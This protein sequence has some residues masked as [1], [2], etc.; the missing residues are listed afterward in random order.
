VAWNSLSKFLGNKSLG[1]KEISFRKYGIY[2]FLLILVIIASLASPT[3]LK[4]QNIIDILYQVAALGIVSIGQTFVILTGR[5]G[6]DLSVASV[7][8]TVAVLMANLTGGE[9]GLFLP[10]A[11]LCLVFGIT[12]G[13]CNGLL[14]TKRRVPPFMATLGMMIILQGL[15]FIYTR[16]APKGNFPPV[17][18]FLGTGNIGPVP[19]SV[20]SLAI[21]SVLAAI[22]LKKTILG[23]QIY[24]VGGNINAASLS[25][26]KVDWIITLAYMISGF[27]AAIAGLY[28][29]GW[30]GVT[31]NWAGEG[32]ELDSIAAAVMGGT[33][34]QGGR[35]GI[36]GTIAGVLI[37]KM[38]YN[39]VLILHL[40]LQVQLIIK[41]IVIILASSFWVLKR[42]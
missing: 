27:M 41:G 13:L 23:R 28:L 14:I 17:L 10:V 16:G 24:V 38:L 32:Y 3:F 40:P 39:L 1:V 42:S 4:L 21:L 6:L 11:L 5:V 8:A 35:G 20:L 12:V 37:I 34:L 33:S 22:F 19:I 2:I 36:L 7:M 26:Y 25:G 31:D 18:R 30:V 9:D 15:R 29:A